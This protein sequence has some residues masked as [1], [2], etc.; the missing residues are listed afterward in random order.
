MSAVPPLLAVLVLAGCGATTVRVDVAPTLDTNGRPGVESTASVGIGMPVDFH[1]RSHHFVQGRAAL[2]GGLDGRTRSGEVVAAG[3]VDYIYW[4]EPRLDLHT[5]VRLAYRQVGGD[6]R[7]GGVGGTLDVL[8]I[9]A[10]DDGGWLIRHFTV[11]PELRAEY[12]WGAGGSRGLFAL[13]LVLDL[14]FLAAGD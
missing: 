1:G 7:T 5:G 6:Q 14:S 12:L 3:Q 11:G 8:P 9:V 2:G 13:P 10:G 4:A